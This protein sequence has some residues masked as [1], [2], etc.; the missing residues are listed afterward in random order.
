[1]QGDAGQGIH[2]TKPKAGENVL[3]LAWK[4]GGKRGKTGENG[5]IAYLGG[6]TKR[7]ARAVRLFG[8]LAVLET[9]T[10]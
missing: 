2:M 4:N 9:H 3:A 8:H 7:S 1:M 5:E 10:L 6:H